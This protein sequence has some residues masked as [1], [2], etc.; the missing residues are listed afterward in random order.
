MREID[1][2]GGEGR[3]G[4]E[5]RREEVEGGTEERGERQGGESE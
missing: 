1:L 5:K 3:R 2:G 4:G